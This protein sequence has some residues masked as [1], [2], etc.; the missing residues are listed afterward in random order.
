MKKV[1][2]KNTSWQDLCH[3]NYFAHNR[4]TDSYLDCTVTEEKNF[5]VNKML[6]VLIFLMVK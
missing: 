2:Q 1:N 3:M 6:L 4:L 5:A